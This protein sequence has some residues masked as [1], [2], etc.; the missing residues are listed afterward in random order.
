MEVCIELIFRVL[1]RTAVYRI[2]FTVFFGSPSMVLMAP[3]ACIKNMSGP[4]YS[5]SLSPL[6]IHLLIT[7]I[8]IALLSI[9]KRGSEQLYFMYA[10]SLT[11]S[12]HSY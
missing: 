10:T 4:D 7:C 11:F 12:P 2:D 1:E 9:I 3:A 6:T 5:V 8:K